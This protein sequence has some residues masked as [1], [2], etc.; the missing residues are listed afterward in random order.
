MRYKNDTDLQLVFA[1]LSIM[2]RPGEISPDIPDNLV[3]QSASFNRF[4]DKGLMVPYQEAARSGGVQQ[5]ISAVASGLDS[6][7]QVDSSKIV[8]ATPNGSQELP[9]V[10]SQPTSV[11]AV[12]PPVT[13]QNDG[14]VVSSQQPDADMGTF[15]ARNK[16]N[17]LG[18]QEVTT[19]QVIN[20]GTRQL[21][22]NADE[23]IRSGLP[24][25]FPKSV[26]DNFKQDMA[27]IPAD[28]EQWFT[29]RH[30]Q[31][32]FVVFTSTDQNFLA[33]VKQFDQNP[34]VKS[35]VDQR[36]EELNTPIRVE[37]SADALIRYNVLNNH[38]NNK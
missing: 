17:P 28:M 9:Y 6:S 20:D 36:L 7:S 29:M 34:K 33:R 24:D 10:A 3:K 23:L 8:A 37:K 31:K 4:L 27:T 26:D 1:D 38:K 19:Q 22:Q 18:A 14:S 25:R 30:T 11:S 32:K 5:V 35:I 15:I 12:T 16:K 21:A 13:I 2:L